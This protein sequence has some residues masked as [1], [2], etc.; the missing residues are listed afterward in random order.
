M[1]AAKA[2][3]RIKEAHVV[4]LVTDADPRELIAE[5]ILGKSSKD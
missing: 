2:Y 1:Q 3:Y 4:K 5:E